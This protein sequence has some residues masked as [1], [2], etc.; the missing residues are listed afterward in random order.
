[1]AIKTLYAH[2]VGTP[3]DKTDDMNVKDNYIIATLDYTKGKGYT[4][5][6]RPIG[7][8]TIYDAKYGNCVMNV[9]SCGLFS[10]IGQKPEIYRECLVECGRRGKAKEREAIE[11]F[12]S[13]VFSAIKNLGYETDSYEVK[14]E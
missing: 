11:L 14:G 8:Y 5:S 7:Q 6:I 13:N 12:D 1:M 3:T 10:T 4:W 2:I 9:I